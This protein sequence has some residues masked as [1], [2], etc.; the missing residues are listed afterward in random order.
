MLWKSPFE[1]KKVQKVK[2]YIK[3]KFSVLLL[4]FFATL[5]SSFFLDNDIMFVCLRIKSV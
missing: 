5:N 3:D 1:M 2:L 4:V